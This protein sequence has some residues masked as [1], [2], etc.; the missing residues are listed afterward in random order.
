MVNKGN[1]TALCLIAAAVLCAVPSGFAAT[2]SLTL[3]GAGNNGVLGGVYV[4]PYVASI[5]GAGS[6]LQVICDDFLHDTYFMETWTANVYS[7]SDLPGILGKVTYGA[8]GLA[9]YQQAAWLT[10]QLLNPLSTCKFAG[11]NCLGDIQFAIWEN[12]DSPEPFSYLTGVDYDNAKDW[13]DK[14][15][16]V[17]YT[18]VD[19]SNVYIYT[20]D[21]SAPTCPGFASAICPNAPSQEF[22]RVSTPEP[23]ELAVLGFDLSFLGLLAFRFRRHLI[24]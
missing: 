9:A 20:P 7:F 11:G 23:S 4:G 21:G 12:F 2:A 6:D 15:K 14:A 1:R 16:A 19:F 5:S 10:F 8:Q 24:G 17:D 3:T 18:K 13:L 22:I